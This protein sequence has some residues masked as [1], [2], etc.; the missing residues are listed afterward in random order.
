MSIVTAAVAA[1]SCIV[2]KFGYE[3]ANKQRDAL[4]K[5]AIEEQWSQKDM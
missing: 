4:S 1:V 2:L 3:R 5:E